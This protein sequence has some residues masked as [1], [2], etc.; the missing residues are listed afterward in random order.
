M[1]VMNRFFLLVKDRC[2]YDGISTLGIL[3]V[4]VIIFIFSSVCLNGAKCNLI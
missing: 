4:C 3:T 1:C 2:I